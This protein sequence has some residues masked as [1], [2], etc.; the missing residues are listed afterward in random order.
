MGSLSPSMETKK[1][2]QFGTLSVIILLPLLL[3]FSGLLIWSGGPD[4]PEFFVLI[5][6]VL[7]FLFCVLT[8]YQLTITINNSYISFK[9]GIGLFGKKYR[10]SDISSCKP[11][12]NS[13]IYG[14][15]IRMISNGWLYNVSGL[16]AIEL[17]FKNK[18][19]VVR[20]GTN[21]P[22]EISEIIQSLVGG[23]EITIDKP[24]KQPQKWGIA[25]W[26][27][28]ILLTLGLVII[29]SRTE[30]KVSL[31]NNQLKINGVYG[32]TIPFSEI[33]Q[34]DTISGIPQ[35]RLR[36]NG[37]AM[38]NTLIGNFKFADGS[39]A[40][41]FIKNGFPPYIIVK[42]NERVPVYINFENKQQTVALYNALKNK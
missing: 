4:S 36:T 29:P 18:K 9:L 7:T 16:K 30:T 8:F 17:R 25:I 33:N 28:L 22:E 15:G 32:L 42:S 13:V 35:I 26:I 14:I 34:I 3:L 40:K 21:N 39:H 38:G 23:E 5:I 6:L 1:Y 19:S 11:V 31:E 10:L 12:R 2:T 37:Y 27:L 20:I 24:V 41:L